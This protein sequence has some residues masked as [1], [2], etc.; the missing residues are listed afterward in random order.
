MTADD[1]IVIAA[2][3]IDREDLRSEIVFEDGET[4]ELL[5][6]LGIL[7]EVL[8]CLNLVYEQITKDYLPLLHEEEIVFEN[9][10]FEYSSLKHNL[11]Y[12]IKLQAPNGLAIRYK[13]FPG[14]IKANVKKAI[15]TYSYLPPKIKLVLDELPDFGGRLTPRIFAYGVAMEYMYRQSLSDEAAIWEHRF[16]TSLENAVRKRSNIVMPRRRWL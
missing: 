11:N 6:Y 7:K 3:F 9:N 10:K 4:P 14:Y 16:L 13:C 15:I 8:E 1:V 2:D 12:I 5:E